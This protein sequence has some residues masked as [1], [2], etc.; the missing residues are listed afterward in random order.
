VGGVLLMTL[1]MLLLL[2]AYY[3]LETAREAP[4]LPL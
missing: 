2:A 4:I 3:M 1:T